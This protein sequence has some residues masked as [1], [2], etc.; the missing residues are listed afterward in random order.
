MA[1]T[2]FLMIYSITSPLVAAETLLNVV[3]GIIC[4][5][6]FK[7]S[8]KQLGKAPQNIQSHSFVKFLFI[9]LFC[10]ANF[11]FV[12]QRCLQ[13]GHRAKPIPLCR[14]GVYS[15]RLIGLNF[16]SRRE[17]APALRCNP[18]IPQIGRENKFSAEIWLWR[19]AED[20]DPYE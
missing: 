2:L 16:M 1:T 6:L 8:S 7:F 11:A 12:L 13:R 3:W 18:I 9:V 17:Q 19:V 15:R 20:V 4:I 5:I 10:R 14:A